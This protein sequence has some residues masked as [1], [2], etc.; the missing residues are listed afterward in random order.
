MIRRDPDIQGG[1]PVVRGTRLTVEQ[2]RQA[3]EDA[4]RRYLTERYGM[5]RDQIDA[6]LGHAWRSRWLR[7]LAWLAAP[8]E[9]PRRRRLALCGLSAVIGGMAAKRWR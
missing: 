6:A 2:M 9:E 7:L 4:G 3:Y 1:R 8:V 5:T